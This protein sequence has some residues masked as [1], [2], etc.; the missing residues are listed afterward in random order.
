MPGGK[1]GRAGARAGDGGTRFVN[2]MMAS[3]DEG[4]DEESPPVRRA[5]FTQPGPLG[6]TWWHRINSEV[7]VIKT[8]KLGG[9]AEEAGLIPNLSLETINGQ[10]AQK[11]GYS[12]AV[13]T[14][15]GT[16][17]LTLTFAREPVWDGENDQGRQK[18]P[19]K[20]NGKATEPEPEPEISALR[21]RLHMGGW[22]EK[23]GETKVLGESALQYKRRYFR[24]EGYQLQYY[25]TDDVESSNPIGGINLRNA[26]VGDGEPVR[27]VKGGFMREFQ[28]RTEGRDWFLRVADGD[29]G[30][31]VYEWTEG[32]LALAKVFAKPAYVEG[33]DQMDAAHV[34]D[35]DC[36][37]S[38]D[39]IND[40]TY[41]FQACDADRGGTIDVS[42]LHAMLD[43]LG[44]PAL[45]VEQ[46]QQLFVDAKRDFHEWR[47][48]HDSRMVLPDVMVYSKTDAGHMDDHRFGGE[49]HHH[50]LS[51]NK[52]D[53][54]ILPQFQSVRDNTVVAAVSNNKLVQKVGKPVAA[55]SKAGVQATKAAATTA[56]NTTKWGMSLLIRGAAVPIDYTGRLLDISYSLMAAGDPESGSGTALV[57]EHEMRVQRERVLLEEAMANQELMIFAEFV[58][59]WGGQRI[60][61]LIPGD[62]HKS[63]DKMRVYRNAYDTADVD[64]DDEVDFHE[65]KLVWMALD[66]TNQLGN[67]EMLHLWDTLVGADKDKEALTFTDFL[68]GMRRCYDD[69]QCAVFVDISKPNKWEL[70]S[71]LVDL[72]ISKREEQEILESLAWVERKGIQL[73]M[74]DFQPMQ[75]SQMAHV[76]KRAGQGQLRRLEADQILKMKHLRERMVLV[77]CFIGMVFTSFPAAIENALV[78]QQEVDGV[79]DAYWVCHNHTVPNNF[80]EMGYNGSEMTEADIGMRY[81]VP[82]SELD[83]DLY[84]CTITYDARSCGTIGGV[85]AMATSA[86]DQMSTN[87]RCG[88]CQCLACACIHHDNGEFS[89]SFE[90]KLLWFWVYNIISITGFCVIEISLLMIFG[91]RF[92]V[93]VAWALDQRLVPLNKDRAFVADSLI[94]AAFE[95]G[96]PTSMTLGVDPQKEQQNSN[97][98]LLLLVRILVY[99]LKCVGTAAVLKLIVSRTTSVEF[100]TF[101]KPWLGTVVATAFWDGLIAHVIIN[102]AQLRGYGVFTCIEVFNEL[103]DTF[104]PAKDGGLTGGALS[105]FG[106]VQ[107]CRAVGVA[108]IK[109]G[110]MFPT[111]ELLLR[112]S[113]QYLGMR[114]KRVVCEAGTLDNVEAFL[115]GLTPDTDV[116]T[117]LNLSVILPLVLPSRSKMDLKRL[118]RMRL[119]RRS[120]YRQLGGTARRHR[121]RAS[122]RT[123][124][125]RYSAYTC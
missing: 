88:Y 17:P 33:S 11:M 30:M 116:P 26:I 59:L 102:Q 2:P 117:P 97:A 5:V 13:E 66:P 82:S 87:T 115:Q 51:I 68:H 52:E 20:Q 36:H 9:A 63:A 73:L 79:K 105:T 94:R 101:A 122:R 100:A 61:K 119:I 50:S 60:Q 114:G 90:N 57:S 49:R 42:E 25:E 27:L 108:I 96:N 92:C 70:L 53:R 72:P 28:I 23:R 75:E 22:L 93:R 15:K 18:R 118:I 85:H 10:S 78:V 71:L 81:H 98:K 84:M 38:E 62:W 34:A 48:A 120:R 106:K 16:R 44:A 124:C 111:M 113:I 91:V 67:A 14:I 77:C 95:L 43:V 58:H 8:V 29:A 47:K 64:G 31:T 21:E 76:L 24:L 103:M 54:A 40:L 45:T 74:D 109:H 123:R 110:S 19:Q 125:G 121:T 55:I 80:T 86:W 46:V 65:L 107:I 83:V 1:S 39:D 4:E 89:W 37:L 35:F 41:A 112:H 7:A 56:V 32:L 6:V 12:T 104:F 3:D 69:P 99:K